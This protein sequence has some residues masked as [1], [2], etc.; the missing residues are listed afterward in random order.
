MRTVQGPVKHL[1]R[2]KVI[3][4]SKFVEPGFVRHEFFFHF[5]GQVFKILGFKK[6]LLVRI[7]PNPLLA[8]NLPQA[9]PRNVAMIVNNCLW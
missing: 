8:A 7:Y 3:N 6:R 4:L 2:L 1:T 5:T 9:L